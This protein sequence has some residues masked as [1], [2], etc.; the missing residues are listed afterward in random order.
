M[1]GPTVFLNVLQ[2]A[3]VQAKKQADQLRQ[4]KLGYTVLLLITDG[5]MTDYDETLRKLQVY[6]AVPLS[7]IFVG[8]GRS[9][10]ASLNRLC[11]ESPENTTFVEFRSQPTPSDFAQGALGHLPQQISNYMNQNGFFQ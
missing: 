1:S 4:G 5:I 3:A 10:F 8:V 9:D 11:Q 7:I 6:R 2:A